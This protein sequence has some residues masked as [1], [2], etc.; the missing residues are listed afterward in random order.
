MNTPLFPGAGRYYPAIVRA[1]FDSPIDALV[2]L[3]VAHDEA[4]NLVAASWRAH[5]PGSLLATLP[6]DRQLAVVPVSAGRW[7]ACSIF[8]DAHCATHQDAER[9]LDRLLRPGMRGIAGVL[10]LE[11]GELTLA[12]ANDKADQRIPRAAKFD[13]MTL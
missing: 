8:G 9:R 12:S 10:L 1:Y 11:A 5:G 6:G 7:A 4:M 2:S 13:T 3:G